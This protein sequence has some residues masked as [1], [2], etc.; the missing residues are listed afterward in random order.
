MT[1]F[2]INQNPVEVEVFGEREIYRNGQRF[3]GGSFD[4]PYEEA[5]Y[6]DRVCDDLY[7]LPMFDGEYITTHFNV[8]E[9]RQQARL[10]K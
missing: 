8:F 6:F 3:T 7:D 5:R 4:L 1:A 9:A 10:V 2:D